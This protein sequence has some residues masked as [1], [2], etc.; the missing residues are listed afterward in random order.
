MQNMVIHNTETTSTINALTKIL[1]FAKTTILISQS[2]LLLA[3][4]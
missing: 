3:Y 4:S 2:S 1:H